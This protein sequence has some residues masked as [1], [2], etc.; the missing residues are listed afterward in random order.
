MEP[1]GR[2]PA[3]VVVGVAALAACLAMPARATPGAPGPATLAEAARLQQE[4]ARLDARVETL[5]R[6]RPS[7]TSACTSARA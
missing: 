6:R 4:V 3:A 5:A 2:R 7:T 1:I